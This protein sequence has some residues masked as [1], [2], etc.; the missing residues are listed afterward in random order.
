MVLG[1][2]GQP[3]GAVYDF[4]SGAL[5]GRGKVNQERWLRRFWD[6]NFSFVGDMELTRFKDRLQFQEDRPGDCG[7]GGSVKRTYNKKCF[8]GD[9]I[10]SSNR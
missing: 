2:L 5:E 6:S 8:D 9:F 3:E 1:I 7:N 10:S 4:N